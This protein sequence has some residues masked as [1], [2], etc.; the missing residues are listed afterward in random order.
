MHSPHA[1][2]RA[3][4]FM[5]RGCDIM[6]LCNRDNAWHFPSSREF[7][8]WFDGKGRVMFWLAPVKRYA[9]TCSIWLFPIVTSSTSRISFVDLKVQ[10]ITNLT[11]PNMYD[12]VWCY[13]CIMYRST[14]SP[15]NI[16]CLCQMVKRFVLQIELVFYNFDV[17][18]TYLAL[19][20]T[21]GVLCLWDTVLALSHARFSKRTFGLNYVWNRITYFQ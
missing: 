10:A 2:S 3:T 21:C 20:H 19:S 15:N 7:L 16:H 8:Y 9:S 18:I 6:F 13:M 4:L 12:A 1:W 14:L 17:K 11:I 5:I